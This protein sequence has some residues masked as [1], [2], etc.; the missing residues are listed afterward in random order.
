MEIDAGENT[1]LAEPE[2]G[3]CTSSPYGGQTTTEWPN[4]L[5]YCV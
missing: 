5:L 3:K 1:R 4:T 2:R